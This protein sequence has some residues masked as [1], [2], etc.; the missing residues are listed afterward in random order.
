MKEFPSILLSS[1]LLFGLVGCASNRPLIQGHDATHVAKTTAPEYQRK[2]WSVAHWQVG[3][4]NAA[5]EL[6][7]GIKG[8]VLIQFSPDAQKAQEPNEF[9]RGYKLFLQNSLL[10]RGVVVSTEARCPNVIRISSRTI[11]HRGTFERPISLPVTG[12]IAGGLLGSLVN[13]SPGQG[14]WEGAGLGAAA[15]ALLQVFDQN[16][17]TFFGSVGYGFK[18]LL[19]GDSSG[20]AA[21]TSGE[22]Y[23]VNELVTN[24]VLTK[25]YVEVMYVPRADQGLYSNDNA[26]ATIRIDK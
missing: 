26:A 1:V 21:E 12:A 17:S 18:H 13:T 10:A 6:A 5:K 4:S 23:V 16:P 15:G 14:F 24:G 20:S 8:P 7:P 9:L 3:A 22:T 11:W 2:L 19:T 25:G